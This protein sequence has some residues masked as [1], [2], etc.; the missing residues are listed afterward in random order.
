MTVSTV[1]DL[2]TLALKDCG[3]IGVGQSPLAED[4]NDALSRLNMMLSM[5][6]RRR[7]LVYNLVDT[8]LQSTGALSYTVGPGGDFNIARPATV[9]AAF[10]RLNPGASGQPSASSV[11]YALESIDAREDWNKIQVKGIASF[12]YYYFYDSGYP[13]G[14]IYFWPVAQ[15][16]YE[17][18]ITT[19]DPIGQ[20]TGLTQVINL[21]PEYF[22]A[23][24][25]NLV[26]RLRV[27]YRMQPDEEINGLARAALQTIRTAN[28][29]VPRLSVPN[30]LRGRGKYNV[31]SDQS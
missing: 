21:P 22:E 26:Q 31:M 9:N 27:A 2:I 30:T 29:Q 23:L 5:W 4:S 10:A 8:Y 14:T 6:N 15:N 12:P 11:D 18:H 13:T 3:V 17:L 7:W 24:L 16:T 19:I 1:G 20:F 28:T 25:Y